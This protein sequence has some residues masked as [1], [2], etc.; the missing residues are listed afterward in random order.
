[1]ERTNFIPQSKPSLIQPHHKYPLPVLPSFTRDP[2]IPTGLS[3][4]NN[5][6]A[7]RGLLQPNPILPSSLPNPTLNPPLTTRPSFIP[8][9]QSS[10]DQLSH[11]FVGSAVVHPPCYA[12]SSDAMLMT[13][14]QAVSKVNERII[15]P[16]VDTFSCSRANDL[17]SKTLDNAAY[18]AGKVRALRTAHSEMAKLERARTEELILNT[19]DPSIERAARKNIRLKRAAEKAELRA[20]LEAIQQNRYRP[21]YYYK[22]PV[23]NVATDPA[24]DATTFNGRFRK[25]VPKSSSQFPPQL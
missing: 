4:L 5:L 18:S 13:R 17:E 25:I 8:A 23:Q 7:Q 19:K 1:M 14:D 10:T 16:K 12:F 11:S 15:L 24:A 9:I 2:K 22:L 3:Q 20:Q 6:Q 21:V